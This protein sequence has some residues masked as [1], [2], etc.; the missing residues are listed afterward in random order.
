MSKS[1]FK[2]VRIISLLLFV[3]LLT[4][5]LVSAENNNSLL[6]YS[7]AGLRK[8]MDEIAEAYEIEYGVQINYTYAGSAQNLSQLQMAGEGD[9]YVPGAQYYYEQAA[10]K[11]LTIYKRDLAY[12]VPV[13]AVPKGNPAGITSLNDLKKPGVEVTLGDERSAAIGRLSQKILEKNNLTEAVEKNVVAK[14]ATVNELVIYINMKQAD[15]SIIWEDNVSGVSDIDIV[16]IAEDKNEI[17]TIP[18]AV[19]SMSEKKQEAKKFV[20]FLASEKGKN[21]FEKHGFKALEN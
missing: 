1:L 11:D 20:D 15:A 17:K 18:A 8:P 4:G 7:G 12:H 6:V 10:K 3:I 9:V 14:A 19:L 21:I 5:N 16:Y 2:S 13:I